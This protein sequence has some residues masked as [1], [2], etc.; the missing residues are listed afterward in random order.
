MIAP[1]ESELLSFPVRISGRA[2]VVFGKGRA[3]CAWPS[4]RV[5]IA[6]ASVKQHYRIIQF[7]S[8]RRVDAE[9]EPFFR[10]IML[11]SINGIY[12]KET[13]CQFRRPIDPF[14]IFHD[15]CAVDRNRRDARLLLVEFGDAYQRYD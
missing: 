14:T 11:G 3:S 8:D 4:L 13:D 15:P 7:R 5:K 12:K 9:H 1:A 6:G 2:G 10:L